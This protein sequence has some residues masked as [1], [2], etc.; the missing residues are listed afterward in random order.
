M[1]LEYE[2]IAANPRFHDL[3]ARRNRFSKILSAIVLAVYFIFII[4]AVFFPGAF[5]TS[6]LGTSA[7]SLGLIVGFCIQ[8]FAFVMTGIY[9]R[10]ANGEF[11][12]ISQEV[13][14][15]SLA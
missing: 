9:T 6:F 15:E 8:A 2:K 5:S 4:F 10:R 7:W 11:D 1:R 13:I 12:T 3:T 14:R